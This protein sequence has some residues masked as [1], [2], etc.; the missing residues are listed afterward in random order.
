MPA[1]SGG[2]GTFTLPTTIPGNL[3][4]ATRLQEMPPKASKEKKSSEEKK[5]LASLIAVALRHLTTRNTHHSDLK[6]FLN[7]RS[8]FRLFLL[9]CRT[10]T[11]SERLPSA[12]LEFCKQARKQAS[13]L[14]PPNDSGYTFISPTCKR[15]S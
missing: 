6:I 15:N 12:N 3:S 9:S 7:H 13:A 8:G 2:E 11:S 5:P 14:L 4:K 1:Q 10:T